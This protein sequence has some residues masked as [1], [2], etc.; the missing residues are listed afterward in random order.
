MAGKIYITDEGK[1]NNRLQP[2]S[3]RNG[4]SG[5]ASGR[6]SASRGT[7]GRNGSERDGASRG[8][9][10][11]NGVS[12][13][14]S[15]RDSS[16][17]GSADSTN[18]REI[19]ELARKMLKKKEQR[20][21]GITIG[22]AVLATLSIGFFIFYS[23]SD[24]KKS[25]SYKVLSTVMEKH[26]TDSIFNNTDLTG[27][28][29]G[30]VINYDKEKEIPDVLPEFKEMLAVNSKLIGWLKIEDTNIDYPV[31]QTT[32]NEY[33]LDH[34]LNQ[35][36]D[37][38]GTIF[39]D[40]NC[41]V[42]KPS[43]NLILY[44]HHMRSGNMFGNLEKYQDESYYEKHKYITFDTL[45]EYGT[46]EVMYVFRSHVFTE[47]E[48]AFKYYQFIDAYSEV[49]F[50]SYM[51]EMAEMSLY[52]TGV[53]ASFGDRLLTLSTCDYQE[54]DGRFVVVAKKIR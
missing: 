17:R 42:I 30:V 19:E 18:D 21:R 5:G 15:G 7:S 51:D 39:L 38:N 22:A 16:P 47:T 9:L 8:S 48:V 11:R 24:Y 34:D 44:G 49:E 29:D 53:T 12:R 3:G 43:T 32:D 45:Y 33:Y 41:D 37:R 23:V 35:N 50:D 6:D 13:A 27:G 14:A 52:D 26:G 4:A 31:A 20:R 36:K 28:D 1:K 46:Y 54:K 2:A 25:I 10:G 40:T